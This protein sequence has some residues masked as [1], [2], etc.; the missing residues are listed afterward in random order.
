MSRRDRSKRGGATEGP[1]AKPVNPGSLNWEFRLALRHPQERYEYD[2][3]WRK[4][5]A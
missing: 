2:H 3:L 1:K 5:D 4:G